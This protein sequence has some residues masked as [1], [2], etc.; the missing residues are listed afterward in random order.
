MKSNMEEDQGP[1]VTLSSLPPTPPHNSV[2]IAAAT[3]TT[4]TTPRKSSVCS[5][6]SGSDFSLSSHNS[7][8]VSSSDD[9]GGEPGVSRRRSRKK[10][11][12]SPRPLV[13]K[14]ALSISFIVLVVSVVS[15]LGPSVAAWGL[16][17]QGLRTLQTQAMVDSISARCINIKTSLQTN[18]N[19]MEMQMLGAANFAN[20]V[21]ASI[22]QKEATGGNSSDYYTSALTL[23][24]LMRGTK[25][26]RPLLSVYA[27]FVEVLAVFLDIGMFAFAPKSVVG[28]VLAL[29]YG[30]DEASYNCTLYQYD[31]ASYEPKWDAVLPLRLAPFRRFATISNESLASLSRSSL[32]WGDVQVPRNT[33]NQ[34]AALFAGLWLPGSATVSGLYSASI[35]AA[36]FLSVFGENP[37]EGIICTFI[38]YPSGQILSSTC[39]AATYVVDTTMVTVSTSN[40]TIWEVRDSSSLLLSALAESNSDVVIY[41]RRNYSVGFLHIQS[42]NGFKAITTVIAESQYFRHYYNGVQGVTKKMITAS[43]IIAAI[44]AGTLSVCT[45]AGQ[46][47]VIKRIKQISET[48][49]T[50]DAQ[51]ASLRPFTAGSAVER[52]SVA[53]PAQNVSPTSTPSKWPLIGVLHKVNIFSYLTEIQLILEK[54]EWLE[55]KVQ[56]VAAFVPVISKLVCKQQYSDLAILESS[57]AR[58]MGSYLFCD[59]ENFTQL[60]ES[61]SPNTAAGLLELFYDTVE[62]A[63]KTQKYNLLVKRLGDGVFL[64][65]GF[66]LELEKRK[67]SSTP[68]PALAYAA[69]LRIAE[70]VIELSERTKALIGT[71]APDWECTLRVGI[72]TGPALHGLLKTDT[73]INPDVVGAAV[74]LAAR[75]QSV[76]KIA[77]VKEL[78]LQQLSCDPTGPDRVLCTITSDM[79]THQANSNLAEQYLNSPPS[80]PA[81]TQTQQNSTAEPAPSGT[82]S[83]NTN[84]DPRP[85]P[86]PSNSLHYAAK[87]ASKS[88]KA[89][90]RYLVEDIPLQGIGKTNLSVTFVTRSQAMH[91]QLEHSRPTTSTN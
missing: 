90:P 55:G 49:I 37:P 76:G 57:L 33:R 89:Y 75:C 80:R 72:T 16:S 41:H 18:L 10:K 42:N 21:I 34:I 26:C 5:A 81:T 2:Q 27:G 39:E 52:G 17:G 9:E 62:K 14:I 35:N 78:S 64:S 59:I 28:S 11:P 6:S 13:A 30:Y 83:T 36:D 48:N 51:S 88:V 68:L 7:Y 25:T 86:T 29:Q 32:A 43:I 54:L 31:I 69:A 58:R 46:L 74:N 19:S 79:A 50:G 67:S 84:T 56:I 77:E 73:L 61:V 4:T 12:A 71:E 20:S 15:A 1:S 65:W 85:P 45:L 63:A 87:V 23:D 47:R 70:S 40:S 38:Q 53:T 3:T 44:L 66:Q 8:S 60:C 91:H 24:M 82:N 22:V